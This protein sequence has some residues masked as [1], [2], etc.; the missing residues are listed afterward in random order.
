MGR[1]EANSRLPP[2]AASR[3]QL[4]ARIRRT[5]TVKMQPQTAFQTVRYEHQE[6]AYLPATSCLHVVRGEI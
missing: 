6:A 5:W 4:L 3:L 2:R 1:A